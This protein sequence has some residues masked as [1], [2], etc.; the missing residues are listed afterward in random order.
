MFQRK[1]VISARIIL[2][3]VFDGSGALT[4]RTT[5]AVF[6]D[7]HPSHRRGFPSNENLKCLSPPGPRFET[8]QWDVARCD[9]VDVVLSSPYEEDSEINDCNAHESTICMNYKIA[10][11][12]SGSFIQRERIM[13]REI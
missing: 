11:K 8:I 9:R 13:T 6:P 10:I 3:S 5:L 2:H 12:I 7:L 4:C 1:Q